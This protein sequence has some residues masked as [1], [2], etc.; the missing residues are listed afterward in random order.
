MA[1]VPIVKDHNVFGL[2]VIEGRY[3]TIDAGR[4]LWS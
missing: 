4:D 2:L 3:A 1:T